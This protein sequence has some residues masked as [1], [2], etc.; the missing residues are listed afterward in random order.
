MFKPNNKLF[1][2]CDWA[3]VEHWTGLSR[4]GVQCPSLEM[5]KTWP[6]ATCLNWPCPD[7]GVWFGWCSGSLPTPDIYWIYEVNWFVLSAIHFKTATSCTFFLCAKL[8]NKA[9]CCNSFLPIFSLFF[10]PKISKENPNQ[11]LKSW[12]MF[13]KSSERYL[14]T[15]VPD[16]FNYLF[17]LYYNKTWL[18]KD[19][20][21]TCCTE[22]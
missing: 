18:R 15:C 12:T 19:V 2:C 21:K 1:C 8:C 20:F 3:L 9:S 7:Q 13:H 16:I 4:E 17:S 22:D 11:P 10:P 14:P 6:I 5:F